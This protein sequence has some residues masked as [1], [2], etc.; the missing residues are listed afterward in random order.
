MG[1]F[2]GTDALTQLPILYRDPVK[3]FIIVHEENGRVFDCTDAWRPLCLPI[4]GTYDDYGMIENIVEDWNTQSI[5]SF[6]NDLLRCGEWRPS[7]RGKTMSKYDSSLTT[8]PFPDI[9][10]LLTAISDEYLVS[11]NP[12]SF[13]DGQNEESAITTVMIH[14]ELYNS[15]LTIGKRFVTEKVVAETAQEIM[16]TLAEESE[17]ADDALDKIIA[18]KRADVVGEI[19]R[20]LCVPTNFKHLYLESVWTQSHDVVARLTEYSRLFA[21]MQKTR[22]AFYPQAG[23]GSQDEALIVSAVFLKQASD[24]ALQKNIEVEEQNRSVGI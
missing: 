21:F 12:I 4:S 17:D 9:T 8:F 18:R 14:D 23:C 10:S 20:K 22:R 15:A 3:L 16:K 11:R 5:L 2:N 7:E 13:L 19:M 6:C 1:C 24:F